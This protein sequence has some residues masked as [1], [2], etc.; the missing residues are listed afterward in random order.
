MSRRV[1]INH[2]DSFCYV[3]GKFTPKDQRN[4]LTK[5]LKNAY[6]LYF[7]CKVGDQDKLWAPHVAKTA[8]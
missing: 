8:I 6:K 1:C 7:G 4:K 3:C 2:P 5:Q